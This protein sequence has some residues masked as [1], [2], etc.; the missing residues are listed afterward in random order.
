MSKLMQ[1]KHWL[2]HKLPGLAFAGSGQVEGWEFFAPGGGQWTTIDGLAYWTIWDWND[3]DWGN[4]DLVTF[5]FCYQNGYPRAWL[6]R[7]VCQADPVGDI[8][9]A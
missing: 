5:K 9:F 2:A 6:I 3:R 4:G 8:A 1:A 7:K